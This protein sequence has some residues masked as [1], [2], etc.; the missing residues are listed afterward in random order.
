MQKSKE[1]ILAETEQ[2]FNRVMMGIAPPF[3][4][5][6]SC[7]LDIPVMSNVWRLGQSLGLDEI[8]ILKIAIIHYHQALSDSA[9]EQFLEKLQETLPITIE[10]NFL[11]KK[12][13]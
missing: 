1:R 10:E 4:S 3:Q 11:E 7:R 2:A 9:S 13:G 12:Y 8:T 6:A 5:F